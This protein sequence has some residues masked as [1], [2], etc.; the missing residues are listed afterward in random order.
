VPAS[1]AVVQSQ[2]RENDRGIGKKGCAERNR[3]IAAE[4]PQ[5]LAVPLTLRENA[6]IEARTL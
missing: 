1:V 2:W 3:Q 4:S 5:G 6:R